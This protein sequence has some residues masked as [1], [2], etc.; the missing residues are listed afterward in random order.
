[1]GDNG[2]KNGINRN[3]GVKVH[4][5]VC[6]IVFSHLCMWVCVCVFLCGFLHACVLCVCV[7][8]NT[9]NGRPVIDTPLQVVSKQD[10][11]KNYIQI[12]P[13]PMKST[14]AKISDVVNLQ[15][16]FSTQLLFQNSL[17]HPSH[18]CFFSLLQL[19]QIIL[20]YSYIM[21]RFHWHRALFIH[22]VYNLP[23]MHEKSTLIFKIYIYV[24]RNHSHCQ[25]RN[26]SLSFLLLFLTVAILALLHPRHWS[27]YAGHRIS[28]CTP[29]IHFQH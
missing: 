2:K 11:E 7:C 28:H 10:I 24:Q 3:C 8:V 4:N 15:V 23:F 27:Y 12:M 25:S 9:C 1:M 6:I 19:H 16:C 29:G 22:K 14:C 20:F 18:N 21:V 13:S 5:S 26:C 17:V